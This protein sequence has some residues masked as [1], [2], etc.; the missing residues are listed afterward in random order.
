MYDLQCASYVAQG[1]MCKLR[2]ASYDNRYTH[3]EMYKPDLKLVWKSCAPSHWATAETFGMVALMPM[4]WR[5][6]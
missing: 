5:P 3:I 6:S 4:I 1:T 2:C